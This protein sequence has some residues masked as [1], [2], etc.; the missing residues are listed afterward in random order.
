MGRSSG[1]EGYSADPEKPI[2]KSTIIL[3]IQGMVVV[4]FPTCCP[5]TATQTIITAH[6]Y[7]LGKTVRLLLL[8]QHVRFNRRDL[9][10]AQTSGEYGEKNEMKDDTSSSKR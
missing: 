2:L 5:T 10:I 3:H 8:R 9:Q 4:I 6:S 1:R 7:T